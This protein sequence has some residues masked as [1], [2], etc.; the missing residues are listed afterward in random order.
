MEGS[1][2]KEK[3]ARKVIREIIIVFA[4][5][6]LF[7]VIKLGIDALIVEIE[8]KTAERAITMNDNVHMYSTAKEGK[9]Y[10]TIGLGTNAYVLKRITDKNG[11]EWCK[12]KANKSVG[13][14]LSENIGKYVKAYDKKDIMVD[15]SKFNLQNN[16]KNIEEF[17]VFVINNN[18]KFVYIRAGGRGYGDEGNFYYDPMADSYAQACEFLEIPFGYYFLE[19]AIDSNE[20]DEEVRFIND[21]VC[22]H[23]YKN[24]ILPIALDVE[25]HKEKGR[26][27]D[28]WDTRYV[29]INELVDKLESSGKRVMLYSNANITDKY[30]QEVRTK[31]WLA[32]YPYIEDIPD[33]WYSDTTAEGAK[34]KVLIRKMVGWQ[35]TETGVSNSINEKVDLSIVYSNYLLNNS[36]EDV[37]SYIT[38]HVERVFGPIIK[39]KNK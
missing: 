36:M 16:F 25:K 39:L 13:Y 26:A 37:E 23:S 1:V 14:V 38:E 30:L 12:I 24:N 21:Y 3:N 31:M 28:I 27:D 20:V 17:K 10:K 2:E 7:L 4:F 5:C 19:E 6:A 35:F 9:R 18:I 29:L 15:V 22:E 32:Y 34:N 8:M 11:I 33:Y